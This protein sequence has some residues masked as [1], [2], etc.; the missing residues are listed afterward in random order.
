ML[1]SLLG[2]HTHLLRSA[3]GS[4]LHSYLEGPGIRHPTFAPE[5]LNVLSCHWVE[6]TESPSIFLECH[7]ICLKELYHLEWAYLCDGE[8]K[9]A[10]CRAKGGIYVDPESEED[11][12]E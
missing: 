3:P 2:G 8:T 5:A 11:Q 12:G 7:G 9:G 1:H 10:N 4:P 6:K